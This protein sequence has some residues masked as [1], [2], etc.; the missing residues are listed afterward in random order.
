MGRATRD[1]STRFWLRDPGKKAPL[2]VELTDDT[3]SIFSVTE[4]VIE[5]QSLANDAK[6]ALTDSFAALLTS[7]G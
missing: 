3:A 1:Y 5:A 4:S 6:V 7:A 2:A